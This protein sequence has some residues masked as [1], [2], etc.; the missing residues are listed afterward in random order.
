M[1]IRSEDIQLRSQVAVLLSKFLSASEHV[2]RSMI[3]CN[4]I[5]IVDQSLGGMGSGTPIRSVGTTE[6]KA[7]SKSD[8]AQTNIFS[9]PGEQAGNQTVVRPQYP[10]R[11]WRCVK[12]L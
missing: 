1:L 3:Q 7:S 2:L 4:I 9:S 5:D 11:H 10:W 12:R 6:H 8:V